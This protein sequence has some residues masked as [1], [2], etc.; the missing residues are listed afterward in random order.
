MR[1][2]L[3]TGPDSDGADPLVRALREH[4]ID[5]EL[6]SDRLGDVDLAILVG[7]S[8]F[9][10]RTLAEL[11]A[12]PPV[13]L[14][15]DEGL[16]VLAEAQLGDASKVAEALAEQ[17]FGTQAVLRMVVHANGERMLAL[18]E[19]ALLP[20]MNG[21]FLDCDVKVDGE[22]L[23]H[24]RGDG[25]I[26]ATPTGST[27]YA[28]SAGGP[29]VLS[30]AD[31]LSVVP[32][33]SEEDRPPIVVPSSSEIQL[34]NPESGSGVELVV[35]GHAREKVTGEEVTITGAEQRLQLVRLSGRRHGHLLGRVR[36]KREIGAELANAPPSARFL[37][38]L[39]EYEGPMTPGEMARESGL[40]KRTVRSSLSTLQE[41]GYV[42]ERASLRDARTHVYDV[43]ER[44]GLSGAER[45][46]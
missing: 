36:L 43:A 33:C 45:G 4:R 28:L 23:W 13:L 34:S 11:E 21:T 37:Y 26:V 9:F 3:R 8:R 14:V 6:G 1:V 5:V 30:A 20:E 35:D 22:L 16:G 32:V 7:E 29:A 19:S 25:L 39:L 44:A 2:A 42:V 31:V 41:L 18:N 10:L 15:A 46:E 27:A 17:R 12:P 24:D 38:K 40:S